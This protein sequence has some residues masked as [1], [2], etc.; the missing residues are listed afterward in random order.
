MEPDFTY[1]NYRAIRRSIIAAVVLL[2]LCVV[3]F[4]VWKAVKE[5]RLTLRSA[6]LQSRGYARALKEHAD[7]SFSEVDN[8]LLGLRYFIKENG[9]VDKIGSE[10]LSRFMDRQRLNIPQ[11]GAVFIA[12]LDGMISAHSLTG[13]A[14]KVSVADRDYFIHHRDNPNDDTTFISRPVISRVNGKWRF[15]LTRPLVSDHG[16][17]EGLAAVAIDMDYFQNFYSTLELGKTGRIV[18]LREDG[19][20]IMAKP[21]K[22]SDFSVDFKKSHLFRTYLP[23]APSGSFVIDKGKALLDSQGRIISYESLDSFPIIVNA[24]MGVEEVTASWRRGT[25]LQAGITLAACLGLVVMTSVLL[26]QLAGIRQAFIK[27]QEQKQEILQASISWRTTF[28]S[29]SSSIWLMDLDRR[30]LRCNKSTE[31]MFGGGYN[32]IIGK[33]CCETVHKSMDPVEGCPFSKMLK[34]GL[35]AVMQFEMNDRWFEI[36]VDPVLSDAGEI[37]GAVHIVSD[38]SEIKAAELLVLESESRIRWLLSAIPD[39]ILFKDG[40]GG[41]QLANSS[42]IELFALGDVDYSGKADLELAELVPESKALLLDCHQSDQAAWGQQGHFHSEQSVTTPSGSEL[43]YGFVRVPIYKPDGSRQGIVVVGRDIT[44]QRLLEQQL[45]QAQKME[46]IGHL[47]GGIAHDFNNLLT[48]ILGYAEMALAGLPADAPLLPKLSGIV[49]AAQKARGLTRQLL[50]FSRHR[51]VFTDAVDLNDIIISFNDILRRTVRESIRI[52]LL[53]DPEGAFIKADR[54]QIE[55]IILNLTVNSQDAFGGTHGRISIE[56]CRVEMDGESMRMHPGMLPGSYVLLSFRDNGCGMSAEVARHIFEPF[57]T[58]KPPGHGTGLGLATVYGIV[59]QHNAHISV[60]SREGEGTAFNIYF[61]ECQRGETEMP[62]VSLPERSLSPADANLLVVEDNEMVRDMVQEM[63][64]LAGYRV[65]VAADPQKALDYA[66]G[67][68]VTIDLLISDVVMPGM[69]GPELYE[70]LVAKIPGLKVIY[71][72][73]YPVNPGMRG[74][75][76]EEEITY[77]QKPFTAEAL[78]ERIRQ[79]L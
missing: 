54:S 48:P 16:D 1:T 13:N 67:G 46:A 45:S 23:K 53:L 29:V 37:V 79:L 60:V 77:L 36:A 11:V 12:K 2:I 64:Q 62:V 6:E 8:L 21:F 27:Q 14:G 58:T 56:T 59:K 76:S 22:E 26:R 50:G 28:D 25:Y 41:W 4:S 31:R 57:Y 40:A 73:G 44:E 71:I 66:A 43:V 68:E 9:G 78:M 47:A 39:A 42:A 38:I 55:Q 5:Y 35:R 51:P 24:N 49:A 72:S 75:T 52:D 65:E 10:A 7:R 61:P 18:I 32:E 30:I 15:F 17:F 63:L 74:V 33:L 70:R 3:S 69:N 19:A 20:M 34:T